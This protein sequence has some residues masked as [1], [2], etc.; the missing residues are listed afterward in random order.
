MQTR[1]PFF[2]KD[3]VLQ[4]KIFKSGAILR[5][6]ISFKM[7]QEKEKDEKK[8]MYQMRHQYAFVYLD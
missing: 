2:L 6:H 8:F 4:L 1:V 5:N 3:L 7:F